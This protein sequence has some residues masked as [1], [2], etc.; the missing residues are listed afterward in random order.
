[1]AN[2]STKI[3]SRLNSNLRFFL[4]VSAAGVLVALLV[5]LGVYAW[6]Q[7][8]TGQ[9]QL[10]FEQQIGNLENK[11]QLSITTTTQKI[12]KEKASNPAIQNNINACEWVSWGAEEFSGCDRTDD[13]SFTLSETGKQNLPTFLQKVGIPKLVSLKKFGGKEDFTSALCRELYAIYN[14]HAK[15]ALSD[16]QC[17]RNLKE[18]GKTFVDVYPT[19]PLNI[20]INEFDGK[21]LLLIL[22][23]EGLGGVPFFTYVYTMSTKKLKAIDYTKISR[24]GGSTIYYRDEKLYFFSGDGPCH[25]ESDVCAR[26]KEATYDLSTHRLTLERKR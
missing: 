7:Q 17:G 13:S 24:I 10:S 5:E 1:M 11:N 14:F 20:T 23:E 26:K 4:I 18:D 16:E 15:T 22:E 6:Q 9:L 25:P 3:T 8:M 19:G 21:Y 12:S 2:K